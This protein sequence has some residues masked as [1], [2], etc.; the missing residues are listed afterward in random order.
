MKISASLMPSVMI[1]A[2]C[3]LS[4][5]GCDMALRQDMAD[6]PKNRPQSPSGFFADGRSHPIFALSQDARATA[7]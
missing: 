4:L 7:R 2:L 3:A 1:V 6:Q 5:S